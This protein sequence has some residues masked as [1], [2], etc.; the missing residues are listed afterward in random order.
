MSPHCCGTG[1]GGVDGKGGDGEG[2]QESSE[3][4]G[5][6]LAGVEVASFESG[7]ESKPALS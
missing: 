2:E 7:K 3:D 1:E 4:A 6:V 5:G